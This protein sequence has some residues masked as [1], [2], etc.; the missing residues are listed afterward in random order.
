MGLIAAVLAYF[1]PSII[2]GLLIIYSVWAPSVLPIF[3]FAILL[4]KPVRGA[5]AASMIVG[6]GASLIWQFALKEPGHVPALLVG[7]VANLFT[8]GAVTLLSRRN[9]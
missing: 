6:A 3:L 1:A 2:D 8:Y 4:R 5:G 7:L 9:P